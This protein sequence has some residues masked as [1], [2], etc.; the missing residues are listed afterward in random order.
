MAKAT[1]IRKYASGLATD[2]IM[3]RGKLEFYPMGKCH[4]PAHAHRED[5]AETFTGRLSPNRPSLYDNGHP[6]DLVELAVT[7]LVQ[8]KNLSSTPVPLSRS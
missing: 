1:T 8:M 2:R 6:A 3:A 7:D 5:G 4:F